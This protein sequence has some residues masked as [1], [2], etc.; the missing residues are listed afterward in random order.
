MDWARPQKL[1]RGGKCPKH[2][3]APSSIAQTHGK[4]TIIVRVHL[5]EDLIRSFLWSGLVLG[6]LHHR[7]HHF[8]YSLK[9]GR[10]KRVLRGS[11]MFLGGRGS[12]ELPASPQQGMERMLTGLQ[13]PSPARRRFRATPSNADEYQRCHVGQGRHTMRGSR[14]GKTTPL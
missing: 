1:Q 4:P 6:H 10:Q 2:F 9:R 5:P 8:V 3:F 7:G 11:R 14:E 12:C 13:D